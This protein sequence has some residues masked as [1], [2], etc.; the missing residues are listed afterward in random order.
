MDVIE[1][2]RKLGQAIQEDI[3]YKAFMSAKKENDD[4]AELQEQIGEFNILR[5][6]LDAEL[7][8][9]DK[10]D[11]K[12]KELNEKI[13]EIYNAI[14]STES[15]KRYNTAKIGMDLMM[16]EINTLINLCAAGQ[17]PLTA[18]ASSCS[19]NCSSC[20]GCH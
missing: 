3:R 8:N 5:M 1:Q 15:M 6:S 2:T 20:S 10:S 9:D 12:V 7:S 17:D 14:M 4:N 19:G 16:N 18:D 13:R 11:E